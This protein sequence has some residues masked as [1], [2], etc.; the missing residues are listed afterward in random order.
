M[1]LVAS[2]EAAVSV[3]LGEDRIAAVRRFNRFYTQRIGVLQ[4]GLLHSPF[5][6]TEARVLYELAQR[7]Q[8]IASEIGRDLGLDPGYLSRIL[9]SFQRRGLIARLPSSDDG[10]RR[11]LSL[12]AVGRSAFAPLDA[13][14]REAVGAMLSTLS[15]PGQARLTVAMQEIERLLAPAA[16]MPPFLLRAHRAGDMGWVASRHGALYAAEYGF[17]ERFEALVAEIV[18]AFINNF[19][20]RRE[21]CWIAELDGEPVGSVFLVNDTEEVAKLRLLLVEPAARGHGIGHGLVAECIEFA[22]QAGYRK[23]TLWTQSIL[24]EARAIYAKAGFRVAKQ[25]AHDSFG[26]HLIGEY[27]ELLL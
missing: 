14:S 1:A 8:P 19:N 12:T 9:R 16:D 27:W 22:R 20:P 24:V 23:L 4:D 13:G 2:S 21:R 18:A 11:H 25:E 26:Q 3:A 15:Q 17:D 5:S 6:L 7:D 10:R